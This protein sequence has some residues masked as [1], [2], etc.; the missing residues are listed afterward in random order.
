MNLSLQDFR[1]LHALLY[2]S[3]HLY[4]ERKNYTFFN[5]QTSQRKLIFIEFLY[6]MTLCPNK[7]LFGMQSQE[8]I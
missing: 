3:T 4:K 1:P 5:K 6:L 8:Y 2:M 7:Y